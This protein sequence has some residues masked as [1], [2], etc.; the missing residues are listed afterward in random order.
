MRDGNRDDDWR[1]ALKRQLADRIRGKAKPPGALGRLEELALQ[2]GMV[3]GS[4]APEL[5]TS[6]IVV[7]AGDHG[8]TSEGVTAFPSS[9]TRE[10]A[11]LVL[12]GTAG[13][14]I[15]ARASGVDVML[16][17]AGMLRP[18]PAHAML[19]D[20]RIAAGTKNA[21][22]EPAMT[23]EQCQAAL[24][25]GRAIDARLGHEGV[26]VV[27]YGEIGIGNS[28][29]AALLAHIV[30]GIDIDQLAGPGAGLPPLGLDHKRQILRETIAVAP[31][32]GQERSTRALEALRQFGGFEIAMMVGAMCAAAT[33]GRLIVVDGFISTSAAAVAAAMKPDLL[34][35]CVFSHCSAE[36]GH[37]LILKHLKAKPLLELD[38]RLGEGTGAALAMP[39]IRA[40]E[41]MLREMAELPAPPAAAG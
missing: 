4:L 14:N 36:P 8:L 38:L 16:V 12:D 34:D 5:G 13:I 15:C 7:F 23:D 28:S 19:L 18:L 17:D 10:I 20:R 31:I 25:E 21:R 9:V 35:N 33:A 22:R 32:R 2:I 40:A 30:T 29:A 27:G 1:I 39:L 6:R 37:R 26:G 3:R 11:K 41:M 24:V